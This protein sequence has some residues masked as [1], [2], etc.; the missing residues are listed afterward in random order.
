M[1]LQRGRPHADVLLRVSA[2]F[3]GKNCIIWNWTYGFSKIYAIE[4]PSVIRMA[5][6]WGHLPCCLGCV[7]PEVPPPWWL[8]SCRALRAA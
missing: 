4:Q 8:F 5:L 6:T 7:C 3:G 1:P 2:D